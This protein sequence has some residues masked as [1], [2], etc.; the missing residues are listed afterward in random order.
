MRSQG[1]RATQRRR[2]AQVSSMPWRSSRLKLATR[3][4]ARIWRVIA[5]I[6]RLGPDPVNLAT[7]TNALGPGPPENQSVSLKL[8]HYQFQ[9][10]F[11]AKASAGRHA[12]G[13]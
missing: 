5:T 12:S 7:S 3:M 13:A 2:R 11:L 4:L 9:I 8:V 6:E 10:I 1:Q